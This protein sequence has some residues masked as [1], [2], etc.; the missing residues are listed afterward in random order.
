M[1]DISENYKYI[2]NINIAGNY[3]LNVILLDELFV[4][5]YDFLKKTKYQ[6]FDSENHVKVY[7]YYLLDD[8][9]RGNKKYIKFKNYIVL[10]ITIEKS[11]IEKNK[12]FYKVNSFTLK[13]S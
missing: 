10:D 12:C 7:M 11:F 1:F 9:F 3:W 2:F 13:I 6:K 8:Y 4:L 5:L